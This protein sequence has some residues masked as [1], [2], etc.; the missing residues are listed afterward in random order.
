MFIPV[1][2]FVEQLEPDE[3]I[4]SYLL[5]FSSC[6]HSEHKPIRLFVDSAA[7]TATGSLPGGYKGCLISD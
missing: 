1:L 7:G 6:A 2:I 5:R 4:A 3:P